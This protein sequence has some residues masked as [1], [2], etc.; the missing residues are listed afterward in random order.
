MDEYERF[1][2]ILEYEDI[3]MK[4]LAERTNTKRDRW[5]TIKNKRGKIRIEDG[6][7]LKKVF[8]EYQVWLMTGIEIPEHGHISPMTKEAQSKQ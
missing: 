3:D 1:K 7:E 2:K 4:E 5:S 8:P 6:E